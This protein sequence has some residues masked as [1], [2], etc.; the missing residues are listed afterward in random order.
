[1]S[2]IVE[3]EREV[4]QLPEDQ[5]VALLNRVLKVSEPSRASDIQDLWDDEIA[6]RIE[7]L[8]KGVTQTIPAS[9]V[10]RELDQRLA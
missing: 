9:E 6:R 7:R 10:F 3:L 5:R 1:M 4:M 2:T 8:D